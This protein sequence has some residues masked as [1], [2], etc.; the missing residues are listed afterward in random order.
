ML[1]N[2]LIDLNHLSKYSV[3]TSV[4]CDLVGFSK[5]TAFTL[6]KEKKIQ[7]VSPNGVAR[8]SFTN[9]R[10]ISEEEL[11]IKS[12]KK[13]IAKKVHA[14]VNHKG[15]TGKTTICFQTAAI[16]AALGYN[17]LCIDLDPQGH[18]SSFFGVPENIDLKTMSH[19]ISERKPIKDM[20]MKFKDIGMDLL[21]GNMSLSQMEYT[22]AK[23]D[24]WE[25]MIKDQIDRAKENYDFVFVDTNPYLGRINI[26]VLFSADSIN[27]I[28]ETEPFAFTGLK[29]ML[30]SIE[31]VAK[32]HNQVPNLS[33]KVLIIPS[34]FAYDSRNHR[35]VLSQLEEEYNKK[36]MDS[37]LRDSEA[38]VTASRL[39]L[40]LICTAKKTSTALKDII[41]MAHE[42][43]SKSIGRKLL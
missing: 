20:V 9:V 2:E 4:I 40:P 21:P 30:E 12:T 16:F 13:D 39:R 15:G 32:N 42:L 25:A 10:A 28:S 41:D 23:I 6:M 26:N 36:I 18:L 29:M 31:E 1:N 7:P 3:P 11:D 35:L 37:V 34:R 8:Y 22:L 14:F 17:V 43:I 24:N 38:V 19:V 5:T 27:V 33:D